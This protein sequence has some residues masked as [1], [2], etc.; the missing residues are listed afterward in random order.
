[1]TITSTACPVTELEELA[2]G[3]QALT[4][5]SWS[6]QNAAAVKEALAALERITR[7]ASAIRLDALA[8]VDRAKSW[9]RDGQRTM[10]SWVASRTGSTRNNAFTA[11]GLPK[12]I[13]VLPQPAK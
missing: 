6:G 11:G 13:H 10:E 8:E 9:Q 3:L 7:A 1:M 2:C 5:V 4:T 12:T